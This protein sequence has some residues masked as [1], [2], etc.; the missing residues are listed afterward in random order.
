MTEPQRDLNLAKCQIYELLRRQLV[1]PR[2]ADFENAAAHIAHCL[3]EFGFPMA[4][5]P[6][7]ACLCHETVH[8]KVCPIHPR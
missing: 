6:E 7:A 1:G 8:G 3:D 5:W 4:D 2:V